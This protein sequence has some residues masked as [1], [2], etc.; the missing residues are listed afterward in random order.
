[1]C[2]RFPYF[3]CSSH[4][5]Q[6]RIPGS[7]RPTTLPWASGRQQQLVAD[8][9]GFYVCLRCIQQTMLRSETEFC[10]QCDLDWWSDLW[11][12]WFC[13]DG[14]LEVCFPSKKPLRQDQVEFI[15]KRYEAMKAQM[16]SRKRKRKSN[17]TQTEGRLSMLMNVDKWNL[18][19][20]VQS[21]QPRSEKETI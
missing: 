16:A 7:T 9:F 1:M 14:R 6:P 19:S 11:T 10:D 8:F 2:T 13:V 21:I 5:Q 17:R 12:F 15:K 4:R 20:E 3:F 18:H